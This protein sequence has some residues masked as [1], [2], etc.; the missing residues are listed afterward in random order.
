MPACAEVAEA[1]GR[2]LL[3]VRRRV[4]YSQEELAALCSLNRTAIGLLENGRRV[5]RLDTIV[6]LGGGLGVDP[7]V[8]LDGIAWHVA[9]TRDG[10]FDVLLAPGERIKA[11][12][13]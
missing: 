12:G 6:K 9:G 8:L 4:G 5:A 11:V 1:F 7:C 3:F 13:R 10:S 2:N